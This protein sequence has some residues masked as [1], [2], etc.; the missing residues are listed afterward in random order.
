MELAMM[1]A[2]EKAELR[3]RSLVLALL[4]DERP[5]WLCAWVVGMLGDRVLDVAPVD[6]ARR[7]GYSD[8]ADARDLAERIDVAARGAVPPRRR[9]AVVW[10]VEWEPD[11]QRLVRA[12]R[13][14]RFRRCRAYLPPALTALGLVRVTHGSPD[15]SRCAWLAR[16][17]GDS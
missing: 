7:S 2:A 1:T 11:V 9:D 3:A 6:L 10:V 15:V 17:E 14:A 16:E 4:G 13:A 12:E 5:N 8:V